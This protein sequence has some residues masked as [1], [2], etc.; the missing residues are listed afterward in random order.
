MVYE[1]DF[2]TTR[3]PYRVTPSITTYSVSR[4]EIPWEKVPFVPRP[5]LVPDPITAHGKRKVEKKETVVERIVLSPLEKEKIRP[6]T[7]IQP[8][9]PYVSARDQ[10]REK[11]FS[12]IRRD[13]AK[14][15]SLPSND[16]M[17][18]VLPKLHRLAESPRYYTVRDA[19]DTARRAAEEQY[20]YS[21][22]TSTESRSGDPYSRP[23]SRSYTSS[24]RVSRSSDAGPGSYSYSTERS[25]R[26]Y[27]DGPGGYQS[28]YSSTTSGRLPDL[29]YESYTNFPFFCLFSFFSFRPKSP[30][31]SRQVRILPGLGKVHVVHTYDRIVPYVGHKRLTV[32]TSNPM[33]YKV[34]SSV[35]NREFD[36]IEHKYRPIT[37][38]SALNEYLNSRPAVTYYVRYPYTYSYTPSYYY[39]L[40]RPYYPTY[41]ANNIVYTRN[42]DTGVN[43]FTIA[44][45]PIPYVAPTTPRFARTFDDETRLIKAETASL[46]RRIHAPIPRTPRALPLPYISRYDEYPSK[47]VSDNYI[48]RMLVSSPKD[49]RVIS[50]TTYYTEPVKKYFGQHG[51]LACISFAGDKSYPRRRNVYVYEDPVRNDIQLLSYYISK[52]RQERPAVSIKE[53]PSAQILSPVRPTRIFASTKEERAQKRQAAAIASAEISRHIRSPADEEAIKK[54]Q[55]KKEEEERLAAER[56][57]AEEAA[58]QDAEAKRQEAARLAEI[59]RQEELAA[60]AAAEKAAELERQAELARQ[61]ELAKQA[62]I[63]RARKAEEERARLEEEKRLAELAKAEEERQQLLRLEEIARQ[64]EAEREAEL[65]RQ[66]EEL[67]ELA[68]QEAELAELAKQREEEE[69]RRKQEEDEAELARQEA[70]LAELERQERELAELAR[71]EAELAEQA[72]LEAE[73][74]RKEAEEAQQAADEPAEEPQEAVTE[75]SAAVEEEALVEDPITVEEEALTEDVPVE[76]EPVVDEPETPEVAAED[77]PE[78]EEE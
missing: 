16:A 15:G 47:V 2:Y 50:Y 20:T 64:A 71:Q 67:A 30:A 52:F 1:T 19:P 44:R 61:E 10:T 8:L 74:A 77:E 28:S 27:G 68:R 14:P 5:S 48:Y 78:P 21:Y 22:Q 24:E 17:D 3:R 70:E 59:A 54:A 6:K 49:P 29:K 55:Q 60:K 23:T 51:Q 12:L 33:V 58:R 38:V 31:L 57:A 37:Y 41:Y 36:R 45:P 76:S 13:N 42:P 62:E 39:T 4:R 72:R 73:K 63:E 25:S 53:L 7:L 26:S 40:Y 65:A 35:L 43:Y 66:A 46:L 34:R 75:E 18:V 9:K 69:A 56:A 32:V 11:V